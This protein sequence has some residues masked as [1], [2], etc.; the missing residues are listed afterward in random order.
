MLRVYIERILRGIHPFTAEK[1]LTPLHLNF[2][3]TKKSIYLYI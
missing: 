2:Q 3:K 1:P